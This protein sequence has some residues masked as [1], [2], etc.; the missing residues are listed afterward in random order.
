M[1]GWGPFLRAALVLVVLAGGIASSPAADAAKRC[2]KNLTGDV[3]VDPTVRTKPGMKPTGV[4]SPASCAFRSI[5]AAVAKIPNRVPATNRIVLTGADDS[6][7]ELKKETFPIALPSEVSLTTSDD[8]GVGGPGL[9]ALRYIV[10]FKGAGSAALRCVSGT[11]QLRGVTFDGTDAAD[12]SDTD[13]VHVLEGCDLS[14]YGVRVR[15]FPGDGVV[16]NFGSSL[17]LDGDQ[18]LRS[19]KVHDNGDDGIVVRGL[20]DLSNTEVAFNGDEGVFVESSVPG[21]TFTNLDVRDNGGSGF[22]VQPSVVSFFGN[23]IHS[24]ARVPSG[25]LT[26]LPYTTVAPQILFNGQ[27]DFTFSHDP[28]DG[29]CFLGPNQVHSYDTTTDALG[30]SELS[31]GLYAGNGAQVDATNSVWR[32][33]VESQDVDQDSSSFANADPSCTGVILVSTEFP[34]APVS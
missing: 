22:H 12:G 20:A 34:G 32:T 3:Y 24:N 11:T 28:G 25:R 14:A 27:F 4:A 31:V 1:F 26:G 21:A 18:A 29:D 16:A 17:L 23:R 15:N 2:P 5:T 6:V 33:G 10:R 9:D 7:A 13:G 30:S 8:P 19:S